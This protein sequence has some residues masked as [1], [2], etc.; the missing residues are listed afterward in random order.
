[1][2]DLAPLDG[3]DPRAN[4]EVVERELALHEP[5]LARLPRVLALSKADLVPAEAV[6]EAVAAW[7]ERLGAEIPVLATSAAT[8]QGLQELA[9][10]LLRRVPLEAPRPEADLADTAELAEHRVFRPGQRRGFRVERTGEGAYRVAGEPVERLIARH[11]LGNEDALAHVER[12]L[13]RMGVIR[14]LEAAGFEPGDDVEIGGV[15]F[16]LDPG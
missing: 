11:D 5:R 1:V 2:L 12:R 8:G 4:H 3:S 13:Q 14:A 9:A 6:E 7:R 16:E 10:E 15:V